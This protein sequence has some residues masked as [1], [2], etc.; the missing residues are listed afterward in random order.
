MGVVGSVTA[1]ILSSE[2]GLS[3]FV[4][5]VS[6]AVSGALAASGVG[7][8]GQVTINAGL[9]FANNIVDQT[10]IKKDKEFSYRTLSIEIA[11]EGLFELFGGRGA[12]YGNSRSAMCQGKQ[13]VKNLKNVAQ[14]HKKSIVKPVKYYIKSMHTTGK[15][16]IFKTITIGAIKSAFLYFFKKWSR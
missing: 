13:L 14:H 5:A 11:T 3:V 1:S 16:H 6:G 12:S 15:K 9:S 2:R 8:L 4:S 10:L 7:L